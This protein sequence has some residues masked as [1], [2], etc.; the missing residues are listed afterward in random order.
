MQ[1]HT[2]VSA[3]AV[4]NPVHGELVL[5]A[6]RSS[7][8]AVVAV[9]EDAIEDHAL[10]LAETAGVYADG[11][12]GVALGGLLEALAS[13]RIAAGERVV[14]VVTGAGRTASG[15]ASEPVAPHL[16]AVLRRL[17]VAG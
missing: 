5:G 12:G 15:P 3:L 6:A 1:A 2:Q 16:D 10:L 8:G 17:G 4:G 11:P 13:G 7:G 9:D 14:L